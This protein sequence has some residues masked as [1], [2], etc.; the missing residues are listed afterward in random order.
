MK[1]II[2]IQKLVR[3]SGMYVYHNKYEHPGIVNSGVIEKSTNAH[4]YSDGQATENFWGVRR[5]A[6][7]NF[8]GAQWSASKN[9]VLAQL[10]S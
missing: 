9:E 8:E 3:E 7:K 10:K 4:W 1:W 2:C 6:S 5:V